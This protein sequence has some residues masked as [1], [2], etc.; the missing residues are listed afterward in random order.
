MNAQTAGAIGVIVANN[1][2]GTATF[3]M[4]GTNAAIVIPSVMVSQNDGAALKALASPTGTMRRRPSS[5]CRS[6]ARSTATSST[7]STATA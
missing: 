5:R 6:T 7:T 1:Q 4:G 3:V 2:G